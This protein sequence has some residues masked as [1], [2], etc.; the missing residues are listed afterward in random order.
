MSEFE[1]E[2]IRKGF[3]RSLVNSAA[4]LIYIF[5][6]GLSTVAVLVG[7]VLMLIGVSIIALSIASSLRDE[8]ELKVLM[9]IVK[10]I[11]AIAGTVGIMTVLLV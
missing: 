3:R 2:K 4:L 7:V 5:G 8:G 9:I 11:I 1:E 10:S 6:Y